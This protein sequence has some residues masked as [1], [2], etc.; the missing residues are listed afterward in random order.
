M[1]IAPDSINIDFSNA[2]VGV[3]EAMTGTYLPSEESPLG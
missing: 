2:V 1:S 3:Q